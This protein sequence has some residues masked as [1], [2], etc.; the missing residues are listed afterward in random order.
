MKSWRSKM[1]ICRPF[2]GIQ[3]CYRYISIRTS[4]CI[5]HITSLQSQPLLYNYRKIHNHPQHSRDPGQEYWLI[6]GVNGPQMLAICVCSW[7]AA[8]RVV[9]SR[10]VDVI[11]T[12]DANTDEPLLKESQFLFECY[13]DACCSISLTVTEDLDVTVAENTL[14]KPLEDVICDRIT[15]LQSLD[16]M[17]IRFWKAYNEPRALRI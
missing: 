7:V 12:T 10:R 15:I 14:A 3:C 17:Q 11:V 8:L 6:A 1:K 5:K 13:A 4:F 2:W 16:E 9:V